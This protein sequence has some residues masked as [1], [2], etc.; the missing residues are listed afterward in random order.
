MGNLLFLGIYYIYVFLIYLP[1]YLLGI[2][3]GSM[4]ELR[5]LFLLALFLMGTKGLAIY[6]TMLIRRIYLIQWAGM[7]VFMLA[8]FGLRHI[9]RI[10]EHPYVWM[11]LPIS[12][13]AIAISYLMTTRL[14]KERIILSSE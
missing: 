9:A 4:T 1:L 3:I 12:L 7:A 11:V 13:D 6:L 2:A 8:L 5:I 10:V 14:S